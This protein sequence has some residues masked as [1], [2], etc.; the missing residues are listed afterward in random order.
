MLAYSAGL[1]WRGRALAASCGFRLHGTSRRSRRHA[2]DSTRSYDILG[3]LLLSPRHQVAIRSMISSGRRMF[4]GWGVS[5]NSLG[6]SPKEEGHSGSLHIPGQSWWGF[7]R[8][9]G[10]GHPDLPESQPSREVS[11]E[12]R[13][14]GR[15]LWTI[16]GLYAIAGRESNS[17]E[18]GIPDCSPTWPQTP[19]SALI[20]AVLVAA[21]RL[22]S[23]ST[24]VV[25]C[26]CTPECRETS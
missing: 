5:R 20:S 13:Q 19:G 22:E 10:R 26:T 24:S 14:P 2:S 23:C 7:T 18:P 21:S 15:Y 4:G 25:L 16:F 6:T 9:L 8:N 1:G 17:A 3:P 11:C 12:Q